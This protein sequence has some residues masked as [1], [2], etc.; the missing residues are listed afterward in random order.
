MIADPYRPD[1]R[2]SGTI[3]T[4]DWDAAL[5]VT[6]H[7]LLTPLA[8]IRG[9]TET[10]MGRWEELPSE[11]RNKILNRIMASADLTVAR[12]HDMVRGFPPGEGAAMDELGEESTLPPNLW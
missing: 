6:A 9:F 7:G 10:L 8:V 3:R 11:E 12:L 2:R 1:R 4:P 5:A